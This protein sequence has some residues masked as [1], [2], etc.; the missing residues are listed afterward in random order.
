MAV[1]FGGGGG[2]WGSRGGCIEGDDLERVKGGGMGMAFGVVMVGEG[3][4]LESGGWEVGEVEGETMVGDQSKC[5]K[6]IRSSLSLLALSS[7]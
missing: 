6:R 2:G 7:S 1:G 5:A 4:G 3:S